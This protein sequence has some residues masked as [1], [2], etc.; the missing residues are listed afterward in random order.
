[1]Y[2]I[3][4]YRDWVRRAGLVSFE[5]A[6]RETDLMIRSGRDLR[7]QAEALLRE[8]RAQI[9]DQIRREPEFV[10]SLT[11]LP[12]VRDAA[13]IVRTMLEAA[14][15]YDVGPMAAVAGAVA[16]F[17]GEGLLPESPQVIVENGGDIFMRMP[18]PVE[19]GLY[20]GADS[21]FTG[22]IK[23][24]VD[25]AGK[26]LGVCT[27]SGTVGHSLSLGRA[28]AV[29]AVAEDAALADAAATAIGN[30]IQSPEDVEP[31]LNDEQERGLL[32]GLLIAV[33]CRVGAY[34]ALELVR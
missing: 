11:P 7:A 26:S 30:R 32:R 23:L 10:K 20:A 1:M 27:S 19:L 34:G 2:E 15:T 25:P 12:I 24:R 18:R 22:E 8:V 29:V 28:D 4:F 13:P 17:V 21:P 6:H 9:E 16:R 14:R 33:R 3:R 31:V 5:V